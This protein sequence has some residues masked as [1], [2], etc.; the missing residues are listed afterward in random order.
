M[1][2]LCDAVAID[3]A[4]SRGRGDVYGAQVQIL[5]EQHEIVVIVRPGKC[6]AS[7]G[8]KPFAA[9]SGVHGARVTKVGRVGFRWPIGRGA[10][11][12]QGAVIAVFYPWPPLP[13]PRRQPV[14]DAVFVVRPTVLDHRPFDVQ[15]HFDVFEESPAPVVYREPGRGLSECDQSAYRFREG[16]TDLLNPVLHLGT[17]LFLRSVL[18]MPYLQPLRDRPEFLGHGRGLEPHCFGQRAR[19][20][21]TEAGRWVVSRFWLWKLSQ[22]LLS[23]SC[24]DRVQQLRVPGV[25]ANVLG[26]EGDRNLE[27]L[28][29]AQQQPRQHVDAAGSACTEAVDGRV[30]TLP[31]RCCLN[32]WR[33]AKIG[34][35]GRG[36]STTMISASF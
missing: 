28:V 33:R 34:S 17:E 11:W 25:P 5:R 14:E 36:A 27:V 18:F 4:S 20:S 32:S 10:E 3:A 6:V 16:L 29:T 22:V 24:Q 12:P 9:E 19:A 15:Y 23:L 13:G 1:S 31:G 26:A 30:N 21:R 2:E 8:A 7:P 35:P